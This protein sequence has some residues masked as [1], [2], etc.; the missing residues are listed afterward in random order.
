MRY[1]GECERKRSE[2]ERGG[3]ETEQRA[4]QRSERERGVREKVE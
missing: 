3:K 4:R 1:R 2:R